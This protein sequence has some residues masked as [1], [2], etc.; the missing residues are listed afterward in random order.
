MVN[1]VSE[2]LAVEKAHSIGL[3]PCEIC[4]P[5]VVTSSNAF[6]A[7]K[8]K[9]ES[10]TTVQCRG[11]TKNGTRCKHMTSIANGYCFQHGPNKRG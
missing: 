5:P 4:N 8:A 6:V 9:G 3:E 10:K 11:I 1:N 2:Q 7:G